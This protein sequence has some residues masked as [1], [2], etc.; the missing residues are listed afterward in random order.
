[1]TNVSAELDLPGCSRFPKTQSRHNR[2]QWNSHLRIQVGRAKNRCSGYVGHCGQKLPLLQLRHLFSQGI[3]VAEWESHRVLPRKRVVDH[4]QGLWFQMH[5]LP[6]PAKSQ[7]RGNRSFVSRRKRRDCQSGLTSDGVT[8]PV[9]T[10]TNP[11]PPVID[12]NHP[13]IRTAGIIQNRRHCTGEGP[14]G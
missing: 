14:G 8:M 1:M 2:Y 4:I 9:Q 6:Q 7:E 12:R 11:V 3:C 13:A 10:S 5:D